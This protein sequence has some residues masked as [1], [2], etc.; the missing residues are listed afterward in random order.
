MRSVQQTRGVGISQMAISDD[1]LLR[2]IRDTAA[3]AGGSFSWDNYQG[4]F[5]VRTFRRRFGTCWQASV[6]A[7]VRPRRS[8]PLYPIEY[9][10]CHKIICDMGNAKDSLMGLIMLFCPLSRGLV[11][12]LSL[13]CVGRIDDGHRDTFIRFSNDEFDGSHEIRVP[14]KW[15]DKG[16]TKQTMLPQM[17]S[18]ATD[19]GITLPDSRAPYTRV[20]RRVSEELSSDRFNRSNPIALSDFRISI[21][22]QM[23]R[24]GA[25]KP[26]IKRQLAINYTGWKR[27]VDDIVCWVYAREGIEHPDYDPYGVYLDPDT[28]EPQYS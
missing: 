28:G 2:D 19:V 1:A 21:G 15:T 16:E 25:P 6:R 8:R 27:S 3:D 20:R 10:E 24:N 5:S 23:A 26:V 4:S 13:S 12:R 14:D 7:G 17:L 9:S 22:C 18:W 11:E